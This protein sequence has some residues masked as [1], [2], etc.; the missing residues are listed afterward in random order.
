MAGRLKRKQPCR[1]CGEGQG[2][3]ISDITFW[4]IA[5][6][7]LVICP[8]CR[9]AQLDPML[10]EKAMSTG[11]YAYYLMQ[12]ASE[13]AKS[14]AKNSARN[15]RKGFAFARSLPR[16]FRPVRIL[17]LGPGDGFFLRGVRSVF[18]EA[19][20]YAWD[21]VPEVARAM[22]EEH[23]FSPLSGGFEK[24]KT[25]ERFDLVI[26][27]DVIEHFA[28]TG[29]VLKQVATL[30]EPGGLF[31]FITPNGHE[32]LWKFYV[33]SRLKS[34]QEGELLLNHVNYFDG[35][36]L[37]DYLE[38]IGLTKVE[39]Y[40]Y[41]F[42]SWKM[43]IGWNVIPRLAANSIRLSAAATIRKFKPAALAQIEA[44]GAPEKIGRPR[45][46]WF[47]YKYWRLLKLAPGFNFGHEIHG[48]YR[49]DGRNIS[50]AA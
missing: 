6:T 17:E 2:Y 47:R 40:T 9:L 11:V 23:G 16:N 34:A 5:K 43:G 18:P 37:A 32:D 12:K 31:H 27:R 26:A 29:K 19:T 39:Y 4:D 22:Q 7:R 35:K 44:P 28:E 24:L 33:L 30:L 38:S 25:R 20:Y 42:S 1:F 8:R 48:L 45:K 49:K 15:F 50:N 21:I 14:H 46:L 10:S 41:D 3:R 36:S 13:S